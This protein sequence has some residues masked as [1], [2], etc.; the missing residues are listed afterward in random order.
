MEAS[1]GKFNISIGSISHSQVAI[2]DYATLSQRVGLSAEEVER[3]RGVFQGLRTTV[4]S[5]APP[6]QRDE[7]L[8]QA[9]E[10]ER[11][12]VA[13]EVDPGRVRRVLR[14]FRDNLPAVAGAVTTV[15]VNPLVGQV[16]ASAG[17]AVAGQFR[18]ALEGG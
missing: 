1:G 14:W 13:E 10:L 4:E 11:A 15:L 6:E 16:V 17:E 7:A 9:A 5:S 12:V 18:D 3:L 2:G 8:A